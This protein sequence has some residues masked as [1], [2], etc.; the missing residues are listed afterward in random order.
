MNRVNFSYQ[1][2]Y[3][4]RIQAVIIDWA[5]STVDYGCCAPTKVFS[6]IF[7]D[8]GVFVTVD[9]VRMFMG[10][11]KRDHIR[12]IMSLPRVSELWRATHQRAPCERDIDDMFERFMPL[13]LET[14]KAH[15]EL[16][17]KTL[18]TIRYLQKDHV[19]I[20]TSTGYTRPMIEIVTREARR[21]GY[22]P[23]VVI[24]SDDVPKGRPSPFM[25]FENAKVLG[26]YPM[27][28]M[29]KI[30]DTIVDIEEGLNAG[31]W[32]I[33]LARTGNEFGLS[34]EEDQNLLDDDRY[35]RLSKARNKLALAGA[36]FV[37]DSIGETPAILSIIEEKLR[38]GARP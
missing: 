1:R 26:L 35:Q 16:I 7:A 32:T 15:S 34:K 14:L 37:V 17:P 31:M 12:S 24:C 38:Q 13:Q 29:V 21:Q 4:G 5:G 10:T 8:Q 30:G 22:E 2:T 3:R 23:D 36:H 27:E 19:K 33:G 18:E 6:R 28:S 25:C 11:H 20:G 9:E